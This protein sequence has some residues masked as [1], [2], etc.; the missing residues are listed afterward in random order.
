MRSPHSRLQRLVIQ[1]AGLLPAQAGSTRV[2]GD[3][4]HAGLAHAGDARHLALTQSSLVKKLKN[5]SDLAH[6][7]SRC[8]HRLDGSCSTEAG[9]PM[10]GCESHPAQRRLPAIRM[11][12]CPPS[13]GTLP[14][15]AWNAARDRLERRP[16]SAWNRARD[17]AEY[18]PSDIAT[19]AI[20]TPGCMQAATASALK[21]SLCRRRRRRPSASW[22]EIV[23]TCPPRVEVDTRLLCA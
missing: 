10:P 19:A 8:G 20:E 4:A 16:P 21:S 17:Q 13:A 14:A 22:S 15:M 6:S 1:R 18:A 11:E 7:D 5:S 9:E 3:L 12:F 23:F 2:A